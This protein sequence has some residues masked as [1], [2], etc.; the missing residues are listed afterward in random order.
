[1]SIEIDHIPG[2]YISLDERNKV[3]SVNQPFCDWLGRQPEDLCGR[4]LDSWM[5]VASRM[6]YLGHVLPAL[7]YHRHAE[8]IFLSFTNPEGKELPVIM[9]AAACEQPAGGYHFITI[10]MQRRHLVEEQ[11]QQARKLAEEASNAKDQAL[12]ELRGLSIELERRQHAMELLNAELEQM[13][14][15]D[16]LTGLANRR[17]YDRKMDYL[18]ALFERTQQPCS[19]VLADIDWF[20]R[21]NDL[22]GHNAGDQVL[23]I[24]S[25]HLLAGL[26]EID[27]LVR[28]GGEEFAFILPDTTA[29]QA[30][31]FA[32]RMRNDIEKLSNIYGSISMSFG[33][34]QIRNLETK[35]ELYG[36]ADAALYRAKSDGRNRVCIA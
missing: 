21:F 14:T 24:V 16:A 25:Q 11:L 9:N 13:A 30:A 7:R 5:T 36:R 17:I 33:A 29:D 32:E 12:K 2:G 19:L 26:R 31:V 18:I 27:T 15:Q 23:R 1:M 3:A 35:A 8:E 34:A 20:K 28:M 22:H 10:P 4:S 6:Y